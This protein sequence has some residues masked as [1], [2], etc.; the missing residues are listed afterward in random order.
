MSKFL[1]IGLDGATWDLLKPWAE[2]GKL[3]TFSMLMREGV[4]GDLESTIPPVSGPAWVSFATGKNPGKTGVIDFFNK[5]GES[6]ELKP[7]SSTD[8]LGKSVWDWLGDD[9]YRVGVVGVPMLFPPYKI[10]GFMVSNTAFYGADGITFPNDLKGKLDEIC[11]G[12][13]DLV[14]YHDV[15]YDDTDL[16]IEDVN[17]ILD[18][19]FA[20]MR[21][22]MKQPCDLLIY[23]LSVTDWVQHLMWK[24][25]DASHPLYSREGSQKYG[26]ELLKFWQR[27]DDFLG[28]IIET[29]KGSNLL[30]ISDHGFGP[31][32]ECLNLAK[33]LEM[34]GYLIR[35]RSPKNL[36]T[37]VSSFLVR[38][39]LGGLT[40]RQR[41]TKV[42]KK[43]KAGIIDQID[44][45]KSK[46]Y[47]L[48]HTIPFGAIYI[49]AEGRGR[50][51]C[52]KAGD[53][54]MVKAQ[55]IND[56]KNLRKDIGRDV[57]VEVFDSKEIYRGPHVNIVPD[58][59]FTIDNWRCIINQWWLEDTLFKNESFS[60]R[61]TGSHRINGIFLAHGPDIKQGCIVQ[62]ARIY[63]IA[64]TILH[65]FD[66]PIPIDMDGI[67]LKEIFREDSE[68]KKRP[69]AYQEEDETVKIKARIKE[70]KAKGI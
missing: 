68:L 50:Q 51:G 3:P 65:M 66:V 5:K 64:P 38:T 19:Q 21:Y 63:D 15:K 48:A 36:K 23:V 46:A 53:H 12:Y 70:L 54:E 7:V 6:L 26:P 49:N 57:E 17:K 55:I 8:F 27:I 61:H 16:F 18:K 42:R 14:A 20:A 58:I 32:D 56:L 47:V 41:A 59:I 37:T 24:Y 30:I 44:F 28:Q 67:V 52:V 13:Q 69:I 40:S 43:L 45:A 29:N 1:V 9:D 4:Q 25:I 2:E 39:G 62:S 34:K 22:L 35:N 33:W 31:Q 11:D 60:N 10:N